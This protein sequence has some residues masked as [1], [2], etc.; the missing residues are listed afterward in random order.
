M[1]RKFMAA[2]LII[3]LLSGIAMAAAPQKDDAA[4]IADVAKEYISSLSRNSFLYENNDTEPLTI[5]GA[6]ESS[7]LHRS[8]AISDTKT[9]DFGD[10][11]KTVGEMKS[12]IDYIE[13]IASY[14]RYCR[15]ESGI[16]RK[17]FNAQ[18]ICGEVS[19]TA[20]TATVQVG[21]TISF[22][23]TDDPLNT[24]PSYMSNVYNVKLM[25]VA[26]QWYVADIT[27]GFAFSDA[28]K[29]NGF[30]FSSAVSAFDETMLEAR[31]AWPYSAAALPA[32]EEFDECMAEENYTNDNHVMTEEE[33]AA[34]LA[35]SQSTMDIATDS[36]K[37]L[38]PDGAISPFGID[39][40]SYIR[41]QP[42]VARQYAW[43]YWWDDYGPGAGEGKQVGINKDK[44]RNTALFDDYGKPGGGGNCSNYASQLLW[45]GLGGS[46]TA[47][48]VS[49][50]DRPLT[51]TWKS[52]SNA[53]ISCSL[54]RNYTL[55]VRGS[56]AIT[57]LLTNHFELT[58]SKTPANQLS[59]YATVLPGSVLHVYNGSTGG[60]QGHAI[61]CLKV[62]GSEWGNVYYTA[63]SS[64]AYNLRVIDADFWANTTTVG[65]EQPTAY[66]ENSP[67]S[68]HT[69]TASDDFTCN[70]CGFVRTQIFQRNP[71]N[72]MGITNG[73]TRTVGGIVYQLASTSSGSMSN[74]SCYQ[75]AMCVT[76]PSGQATWYSKNN[77]YYIDQSVLF[78]QEGIWT[79]QI[80]ARDRI[81]TGTDSNK[82][83]YT[84]K[85][86]VVNYGT[87]ASNKEYGGI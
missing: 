61:Y 68:G 28:S 4:K 45:A 49:S 23:Y 82:I 46:N 60:Q 59:S 56:T 18:Y 35:E 1:K 19:Y 84:F 52:R 40:P 70:N 63:N 21:E 69:Y 36:T 26:G 44:W 66:R 72:H 55:T 79:I 57:G 65:V 9:V 37:A 27:D 3:S 76:S 5:K 22:M 81:S 32:E 29:E 31:T 53:F 62:T 85:I 7:V 17:D 71:A 33:V 87:L 2:I 13:D 16:T 47:A 78:N 77:S 50:V 34:W 12:N 10:E 30:D 48:A 80:D 42:E 38:A 83:S 20:D 51:G 74:F 8:V 14:N 54:F 58:T 64:S 24:E 41:P 39:I 73:T 67:C 86:R 15:Q 25:N 43:T 6:L 75:L 11:T